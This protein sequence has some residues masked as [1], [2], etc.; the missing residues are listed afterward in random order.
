MSTVMRTVM[1]YSE[2]RDEC[3][4]VMNEAMNTVIARVIEF[5]MTI[6]HLKMS[7]NRII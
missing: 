1:E 7:M 4:G 6:D 3:T 2:C 5:M